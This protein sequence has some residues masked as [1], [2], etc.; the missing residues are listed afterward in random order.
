M[1]R[2]ELTD[3]EVLDLLEE[4]TTF[5][6]KYPPQHLRFKKV[7]IRSEGHF[8]VLAMGWVE[9]GRVHT[10]VLHIEYQNKK[11]LVY[12]NGTNID[13]RDWLMERGVPKKMIIPTH[14]PPEEL[15]YIEQEIE[16]V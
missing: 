12:Y 11:I 10:P 6:S 9:A 14:L 7:I 2:K 5:I 13:I 4:I 8:E 1:D 16:R 3:K 15:K